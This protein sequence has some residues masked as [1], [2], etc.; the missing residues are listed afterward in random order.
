MFSVFLGYKNT[1]NGVF[2]TFF[3]RIFLSHFIAFLSPLNSHYMYLILFAQSDCM[4]CEI[5]KTCF[6]LF[7]CVRTRG[8][9]CSFL[10]CNVKYLGFK[11]QDTEVFANFTT[12]QLAMRHNYRFFGFCAAISSHLRFFLV[13]NENFFSR[14]YKKLQKVQNFSCSF[15]TSW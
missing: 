11:D 3:C 4:G 8:N 7:W 6:C 2:V 14:Y 12:R 5:L 9:K 13:Q 1:R 10:P 15:F